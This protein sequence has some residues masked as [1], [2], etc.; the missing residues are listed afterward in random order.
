MNVRVRLEYINVPNNYVLTHRSSDYVNVEFNVVGEEVN[1][2]RSLLRNAN[3]YINLKDIYSN[4]NDIINYS[5]SP[6]SSV[7]S[8]LKEYLDNY[9]DFQVA[10]DSVNITLEKSVSKRVP[11]RDE[12]EYVIS[13]GYMKLPDS[14]FSTDS[15]TISGLPQIVGDIDYVSFG[16]KIL[17][18]IKSSYSHEYD[19]SRYY[20]NIIVDPSSVVYTINIAEF[21]ETN[22]KLCI[23]DFCGGNYL[24]FPDSVNIKFNVSLADYVMITP[25]LFKIKVNFPEHNINNDYNKAYISLVEFPDYIDVVDVT[26]NIV[27]YLIVVK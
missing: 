10:T 6:V 12:F 5:F 7:K 8:Q 3:V 24:F 16:H 17:G 2:I 4:N 22:V 13:S 1:Q 21:T 9:T 26:P 23:S 27:D 14:G 25:L 20:S 11:I 15:V 19:F 18:E